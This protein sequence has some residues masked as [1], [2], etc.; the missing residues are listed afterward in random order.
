MAVSA[1]APYAPTFAAT[2]NR[3]GA[4]IGTGDASRT[5]ALAYAR[6]VDF[7]ATA[8]QL[9][10]VGPVLEVDARG[11][12]TRMA[13][14][15]AAVAG[16]VVEVGDIANTGAGAGGAPLV[17]SVPQSTYE[18]DPT[19]GPTVAVTA[20][21]VLRG[22][23]VFQ[24][25][26]TFD[27]VNI[28]NLSALPVRVR[29]VDVFNERT[30]AA[31][32]VSASA[33]DQAGFVY[34]PAAPVVGSTAVDIRGHGDVILDGVIANG[35][36]TTVVAADGSAGDVRTTSATALTE[37]TTLALRSAG[38]AVGSAA[39]RLRTTSTLLTARASGGVYVTDTGAL[40]VDRVESLTGAADLE[41]GGAITDARPGDAADVSGLTVR[42]TAHGGGIG[43][44]AD[45]LEIAARA[46]ADGLNATAAAGIALTQVGGLGLAVNQVFAQSGSISVDVA[47]DVSA[48]QDLL[49]PAGALVRAPF[50][51]V[52]L[53]AGDDLTVA[54]GGEVR[55]GAGITL[56]AD[57]GAA[58]AAGAEV[59]LAG[60]L[61]AT[62][63]LVE[64][65]GAA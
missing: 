63:V 32:L 57:R 41:A 48:G 13:G 37:S 10:G 12:F 22:S 58:D 27:E 23:P 42:L 34:G 2:A 55:A 46:A 38:G 60:L 30:T 5:A 50:G 9:G 31:G 36:G 19:P 14:L 47:D 64:T 4:L 29:N 24:F 61:N 33:P 59:L 1:D 16:G 49:V 65:G 18:V 6:S 52:T 11:N 28:R 15:S 43:T 39:H 7:S 35:L 21:A 25:Q 26:Q 56:R 51:A 44:A 20:T 8:V 17:F 54:T 3:D 40:E 53:A 62:A 45:P